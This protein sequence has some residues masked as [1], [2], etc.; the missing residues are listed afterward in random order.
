MDKIIVLDF[1]S[2]YNQLIARRVREL[3]VYSEI[4]PFNVDIETL[5]KDDVKTEIAF[6]SHLIIPTA[7]NAMTLDEIGSINKLSIA[8][9]IG[10]VFGLGYNIG[11]DYFGF[12]SGNLTY[13]L[14]LGLSI[15]DKVSFYLEPY[16]AL[17]ELDYHKSSFDAGI[18]YLVED[19]LQLDLSAGTG[20]NHNMNYVS[21]GCSINIAKKN[22][23]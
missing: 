9:D 21:I 4:L 19:N 10:D 15:S 6:L 16:G 17:E 5:K 3:G 18:A 7:K 11:Y 13:S 23:E 20:L 12:G 2:Q 1:G 8:H 22:K 14:A